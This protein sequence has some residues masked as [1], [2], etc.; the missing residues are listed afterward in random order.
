M[1]LLKEASK[2]NKKIEKSTQIL[3]NST[4]LTPVQRQA[5]EAERSSLQV[6][7]KH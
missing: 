4:P 6:Q 5:K 2:L 3:T 7:L 1:D